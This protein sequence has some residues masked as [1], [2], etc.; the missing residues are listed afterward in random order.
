[1]QIQIFELFCREGNFRRGDTAF[2]AF[3][4]ASARDRERVYILRQNPG[5]RKLSDGVARLGGKLFKPSEP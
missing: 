5:K 3:H 4:P 2:K 1:M